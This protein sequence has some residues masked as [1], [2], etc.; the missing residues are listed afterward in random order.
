MVEIW[1][2]GDWYLVDPTELAPLDGLV[3]IAIGR[4]ATDIA[5]MTIFGTA[6]LIEQTIRVERIDRD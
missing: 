4:D 2:A 6:E 5:F 3:R 1:L